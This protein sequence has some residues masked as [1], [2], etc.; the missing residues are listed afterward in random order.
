MT[1]KT[2]NSIARRIQALREPRSY[3]VGT[4]DV[5]T[6]QPDNILILG[7]YSERPASVSDKRHH[8]FLLAMNLAG[9]GD[10]IVDGKRYEL[11]VGHCRLIFPHQWHHFYFDVKTI[12]WIFITFELRRTEPLEPLRNQAVI[13]SDEALRFL[14]ILT[15]FYAGVKRFDPPKARK[16]VL[17]TQLLLNELITS[18]SFLSGGRE[19]NLIDRI[20]QFIIANL[21]RPLSVADIAEYVS[22]SPSRLRA[23]YRETMGI[24]IGRYIKEIKLHKAQRLLGTT[25]MRIGEIALQ[26]G[27][28][29]VY[30]FSH[31]FRNYTQLSPTTY[32]KQILSCEK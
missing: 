11:G 20:N 31:A 27:Y 17:L 2:R 4:P 18:E 19:E 24:S 10:V 16:V 12:R 32:R 23:I 13:L 7:R 28:D 9:R 25:D 1:T 5:E 26:C 29:S 22:Y 21:A 8:R 6:S 3:Y 15:E 30:S 14:D